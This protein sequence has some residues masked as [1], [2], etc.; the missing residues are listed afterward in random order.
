MKQT[1][2]KANPALVGELLEAK[3]AELAALM[4]SIWRLSSLILSEGMPSCK[5]IDRRSFVKA[6]AVAL[7]GAA[8]PAADPRPRRP[9]SAAPGAGRKAFM[10]G[11]S[12]RDRP[13]RLPTAQGGRIR[14]R[15]ADQ[16]QP[17]RSRRRC[18][19]AR[20]KTGLVIHGVSGA[21][22]WQDPLSDP[23]PEVV[24]RGMAAIRQEFHDCKAYGGTTVLVVPAVVNKKVS[25]RDAYTRS[26]ENIRKLIPDAEK[27]RGQDRHRGSLEQV[28]AEPRRVRPLHRRVRQPLGRRLLRCRQRRRVRLSRGMDPRAGQAHPQDPHQG[29]RQAQAVRL[30]ARRG[31]DRLARRPPGASSTSATM[32]GSPPRS[33]YGD[34]DEL[35]DVVRRMNQIL[36]LG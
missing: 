21:Q 5:S 13:A 8:C 19:A 10:L 32:A 6:S 35:K 17:A 15:R 29:I 16:P 24:E 4:R 25:Y 28:P 14:G 11:S 26:Q 12:P 22:H 20:D 27:A 30:Q 33:A 7:A 34:L 2:G 3:L 31:R 18:S 1:G 23:D 9:R 36:Q